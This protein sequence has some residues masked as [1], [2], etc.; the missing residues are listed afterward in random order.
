[1]AAVLELPGPL[2]EV[3]DRL[4]ELIGAGPNGWTAQ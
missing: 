1:V 2:I 4:V 3:P